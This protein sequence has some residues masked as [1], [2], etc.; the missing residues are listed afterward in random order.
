MP[1]VPKVRLN[2]A[3]VQQDSAEIANV[4]IVTMLE[5]VV[6]VLLAT[7]GLSDVFSA[8]A[9]T[10]WLGGAAQVRFVP[11]CL[12]FISECVDDCYFPPE[13]QNRINPVPGCLYIR[14]YLH[15]AAA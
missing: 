5:V 7:V 11:K 4:L 2:T 10:V 12:C 8:S 14:A 1:V 3:R 15:V 13:C 6:P 9:I